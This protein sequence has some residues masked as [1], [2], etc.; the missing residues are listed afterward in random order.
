MATP[1]RA[2][3]AGYLIYDMSAEALGKASA[4]AAS[5]K[6]PAANWFNPSAISFMPGYQFSAGGVFI[7]AQNEFEPEEGGDP[8][9]SKTGT[10]FL[11]TVFG[12]FEILDWLHAGLGVATPFGLGVE[13]PEDW[14]GREFSIAA[15]IETV[16]INPNVS[17][18]VWRDV[19]IAVGFN[20][21]YGAVDMTNGLPEPIGGSVRIGGTT[22]GYGANAAVTW[23]VFPD[24]FHL[25]FAY[26]SR[27]E[28]AFD[29]KADFE[30]GAEEFEPALVDQGGS[31]EITLPDIFTF[32]VM[33]KP[34]PTVEL[35]F[36]ANLVMWSTYD[37]IRLDFEQE[38][39]PDEVLERNFRNSVTLRLGA[40]FTLPVNP[41]LG[42]FQV[43]MGLIFDQNPSPKKTLA[44]SLP[45]ADRVDLGLGVGYTYDWFTADIG[46]LLVYF[47][48]SKAESGREGP[49]GTYN[50]I[51][52]LMGL[53][54]TARFGVEPRR[55]A[56]RP[57]PPPTRIRTGTVA[58]PAD[59]RRP[60]PAPRPEPR[61]APP[62]PPPAPATSPTPDA[63]PEGEPEPDTGAE[64]E[65]GA[66]P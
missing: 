61:T 49:E 7:V 60:D 29:G 57:V 37:E 31:S 50:S 3:G 58:P 6:E 53:T 25:A 41:E 47:L 8:I 17:F 9:S 2:Q 24:L 32:G 5:T 12:T 26:R 48:P 1:Q 10:F 46:Y 21:V 62:P 22:F 40:D 20:L 15:S 65:G 23:R 27:V 35:T 43:R 56:V 45:D 59:P 64:P 39:T 55:P 4:V 38:D 54:L 33:Y 11:P 19:S 66:S 16:N 63:R 28:L 13:W 14:I 30:P 18:K 51:A 42:R 44:P 52:H 34:T 36:D